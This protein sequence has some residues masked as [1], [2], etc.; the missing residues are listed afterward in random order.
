MALQHL[1]ER[2]RDRELRRKDGQVRELLE[3][4]LTHELRA[5]KRFE[6]PERRFSA[7]A[8]QMIAEFRHAMTQTGASGSDRPQPSTGSS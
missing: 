2:T 3:D 1:D 5:L 4:L 7:M 8:K 6:R